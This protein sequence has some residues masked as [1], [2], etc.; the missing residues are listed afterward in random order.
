MTS[1][2][3]RNIIIPRLDGIKQELSLLSEL[4]RKKFENFSNQDFINAILRHHLADIEK[5]LFHIKRFLKNP[6][7]FGFTLE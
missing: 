4:S 5:F 1:P 2:L 7:K 6:R 3:Q